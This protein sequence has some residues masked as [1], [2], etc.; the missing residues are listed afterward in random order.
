MGIFAGVCLHG[1]HSSK[2]RS[3]Q[4]RLLSK[5]RQLCLG[6]IPYSDLGQLL[7]MSENRLYVT[8]TRV[9]NLWESISSVF[10]NRNTV[11]ARCLAEVRGRII[12]MHKAIG[13]TVYLY[14]SYVYLAIELGP[15]HFLL[16]KGDK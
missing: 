3:H 8:D 5:R 1:C 9:S 4:I 7:N 2:S 13:S 14:T 16:P 6:T 11:T 15:L 10:A 12:S